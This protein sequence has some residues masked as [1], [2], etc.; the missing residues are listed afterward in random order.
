[1]GDDDKESLEVAIQ[2]IS[3]SFH[4]DAI[5][6]A[7]EQQSLLDI[8][9]VF[10]RTKQKMASSSQQSTSGGGGSAEEAEQYKAQGNSAMIAKSFAEAIDWYTKA[11][12]ISPNNKVYL[13][14]RAAAYSQSD[15]HAMAAQD[16]LK[17]VEIDSKYSKAWSRLGHA[18][19]AL[20]DAKGAMEAYDNGR[21]IDPDN[22]LLQRG[23]TTAKTKWEE[24][25]RSRPAEER[26]TS[27][28]NGGGGMPDLSG[29]MGML[30]GAGGGGGG[31]AGGGQNML[32]S[33]M[34]NPQLMQAAQSMAQSGALNNLM[35][36]PALRN[37]MSQFGSGNSASPQDV[38]NNPDIMNDPQIRSM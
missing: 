18:R 29:L 23:Y 30:G 13:S 22:Q 28:P 25:E 37:I 20:G 31:A 17:A 15:Q 24:L 8:F 34:S 4:V 36:N 10:E 38:L 33:L 32:S 14:N 35:Q 19:Y 12:Q 21:K 16:A 27:P 1:M 5:A 26:S 11:L 6:A 7:T 9:N 2:C 3:D